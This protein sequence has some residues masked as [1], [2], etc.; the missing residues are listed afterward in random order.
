MQRVAFTN[1]CLSRL[2][3]KYNET[4][5]SSVKRVAAKLQG[6]EDPG[7]PERRDASRRRT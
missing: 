6:Q 7:A 2:Q 4:V 3:E 1:I 5:T